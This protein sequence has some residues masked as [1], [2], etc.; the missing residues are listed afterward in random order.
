MLGARMGCLW[1]LYPMEV[2]FFFFFNPSKAK[3]LC[4]AQESGLM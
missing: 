2:F 4:G 1:S 3:E